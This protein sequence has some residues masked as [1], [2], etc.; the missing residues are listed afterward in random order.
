V[1]TDLA[2]ERKRAGLKWGS[3]IGGT[4]VGGVSDVYRKLDGCRFSG[5]CSDVSRSVRSAETSSV[6]DWTIV[7]SVPIVTRGSP[8]GRRGST[9]FPFPLPLSARIG[10]LEPDEGAGD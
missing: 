4:V 6:R 7:K 1:V 2:I 5:A 3:G 9:A 8:V 10:R